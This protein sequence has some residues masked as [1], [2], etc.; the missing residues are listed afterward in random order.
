ML[1][2]G[3]VTEYGWAKLAREVTDRKVKRKWTYKQIEDAGGPS[4]DTVRKI[5]KNQLRNPKPITFTRLDAG[6]RWHP[7]SSVNTV[8]RGADPIPLDETPDAVVVFDHGPHRKESG[9]EASIA[10][11]RR[12]MELVPV[13]TED[14]EA[15]EKII[16]D[17][18]AAR[19]FLG[20][21]DSPDGAARLAVAER[22]AL[23]EIWEIL[24]KYREATGEASVNA[25]PEGE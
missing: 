13:T 11:A 12:L 16:A 2:G 21:P 18:E 5:E 15:V 10:I 23:K 8:E 3:V 7:A 6:M 9:P 4:E 25:T 17:L 22:D 1:Y 19:R 14:R 20:N 24:F